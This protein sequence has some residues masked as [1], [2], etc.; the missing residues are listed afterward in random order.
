MHAVHINQLVFVCACVCRY[1]LYLCMLTITLSFHGRKLD[2]IIKKFKLTDKFKLV[3]NYIA[4]LCS[5]ST[6]TYVLRKC[7]VIHNFVP[8]G[9]YCQQLFYQVKHIVLL[10]VV[11]QNLNFPVY[12]HYQLQSDVK[13]SLVVHQQQSFEVQ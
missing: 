6:L 9:L 11:V 7:I 12:Q 5:Y 8:S 13:H 4:S 3:G 1:M 2:G 10:V